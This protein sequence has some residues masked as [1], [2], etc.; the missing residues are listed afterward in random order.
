MPNG[1]LH[2]IDLYARRE[3]IT[4]DQVARRLRITRATLFNVRS[5]RY[6][7]GLE[8]ALRIRDL[9]G[10]ASLDEVYGLQRQPETETPSPEAA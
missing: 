9:C 2:P 3:G 4:L 6:R 10:L 7:P 5:G 8:L 1:A